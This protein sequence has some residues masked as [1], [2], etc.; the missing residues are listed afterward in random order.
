M[1]AAL[2]A[3]KDACAPEPSGGP[4]GRAGS[5][6]AGSGASLLGSALG[7]ALLAQRRPLAAPA[8]G[9]GAGPASQ[10][11]GGRPAPAPGSSAQSA[12]GTSVPLASRPP[13]GSAAPP[14]W[15]GASQPAAAAGRPAA[16]PGAA[17]YA[18]Y[19]F[20]PSGPNV[21]QLYGPGGL[22]KSQRKKYYK[23]MR[24]QGLNPYPWE[25]KTTPAPAAPAP[26]STAAALAAATAGEARAPCASGHAGWCS[27]LASP[28]AWFV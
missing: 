11:P 17:I 3:A 23:T 26:G 6:R 28:G 27:L 19:G 7:S 18:Q 16:P 12:W 8:T 22:S 14:S 20:G 24:Q 25:Q 10:P 21:S 9:A 5:G 4:A 1:L 15:G 2:Q 13:P